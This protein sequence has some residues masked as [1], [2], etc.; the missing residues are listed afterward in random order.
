[1]TPRINTLAID[2]GIEPEYENRLISSAKAIGWRVIYPT[3]VPFTSEILDVKR[4]DLSNPGVWYHGDI[5]T[6][7]V[8]QATLPWQVHAPWD[9]QIS[10]LT[11]GPGMSSLS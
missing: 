11:S 7:K 5:E 8:I 9:W 10:S 2:T 4:E 1:M 3:R 6:A